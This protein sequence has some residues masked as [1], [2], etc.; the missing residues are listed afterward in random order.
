MPSLHLEVHEI[1]RAVLELVQRREFAGAGL[2]ER[3]VVVVKHRVQ[4]ERLR[5]RLEAIGELQAER[6][7]R[8]KRGQARVEVGARRLGRAARLLAREVGLR[9]KVLD[10]LGGDELRA[11]TRGRGRVE[12]RRV[13]GRPSGP[14]SWPLSAETSVSRKA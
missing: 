9:A 7:A 6:I 14:A 11:G 10:L 8:A 12:R 1:G 5:V 2:D 13:P 4:K 3:P